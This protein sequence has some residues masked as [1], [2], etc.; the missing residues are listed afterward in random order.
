MSRKMKLG[1]KLILSFS[2]V[3]LITLLLGIVGY[4][5]ATRSD[6]AIDEIGVVRLPSVDSLLIIKENAENIRGTMRTLAIPG[7]PQEIRQRQ[8]E[9]L[10]EARSKYEKAWKIYEPLPQ[11]PEEAALWKRFVPAWN[12]WREENNKAVE[13]SKQIDQGGITDPTELERQLEQFTKDHYILVQRVLHLLHVKDAMFT[14]GED[15]TACHAGKWLSTF[16]TSNAQLTKEV[17]GI[18]EPHQRFHEAVKKIKQFIS[19]GNKGDAQAAYESQMI[20]A[21]HEVFQHFDAMLKVATDS[22]AN[23]EKMQKLIFGPVTQRQLEAMGLLDKIVQINRDVAQGEVKRSTTQSAFLKGLSLIAMLI[24][25]VLALA[26]GILI[27]RSIT[28]PIH[29]IIAGL[30]E[31]A[32]Q[33]AAASSQVSSSSQSLAQG[34]SQQAAALE[35]TTSSLQEMSSMTR[36][37]ADSARQADVLMGEAARIVEMAN[38]SMG[39]LTRSMKEVSAASEETAKIIKTIDEIAFQTNLLALNAAVEAARAGEAGAGFAVVA[40]EVRNLAMR[41]AEAAKNTANLIEGTVDKVKEGSVVVEK[42]AEAFTQM[43]ESTVKVK[44]LVAEIAAASNEQAGGVDQINRAVQEMNGVTQ[45]V[46]ANAEESASAS[47]ELNAQSEQ[48]K[49]A[50]SELAALVGS[51]SN[52]FHGPA[53]MDRARQVTTPPRKKAKLLEHNQNKAV[54]PDQVIPLDDEHFKSF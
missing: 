37:N 32:E 41:A 10:A 7:L 52:G 43:T 25:V 2:V 51:R 1:A 44:E 47:Q 28:K 22:R 48:M 15:H 27:T 9:N 38:T 45:Q 3:A 11:T 24:G 31:G 13:L 42:T 8:A 50:V 36:S 34:S 39:D 21:M 5:G 54:T 49:G 26:L 19:A 35:E 46:A 4:Y 20:P 30:S 16:K 6:Q 14:G 18:I 53:G 17:K 29:R 23:F 12:A 40:E 33:V